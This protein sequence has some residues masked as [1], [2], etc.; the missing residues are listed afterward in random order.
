MHNSYGEYMSKPDLN[1]EK[2]DSLKKI[3]QDLRLDI[4]DMTLHRF[5][6][7]Y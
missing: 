3:A 7:L 4:L 6:F 1:I 5:L 2:L